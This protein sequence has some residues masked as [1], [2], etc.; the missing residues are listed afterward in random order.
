M[1]APEPRGS[2]NGWVSGLAFRCGSI[3]LTRRLVEL[4]GAWEM[5]VTTNEGDVKQR[6]D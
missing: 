6:L 3:D 1:T 2:P 5:A 4:V